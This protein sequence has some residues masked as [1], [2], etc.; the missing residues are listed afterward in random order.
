MRILLLADLHYTLPQFDWLVQAAPAF[1]VVAI[2][3][4]LLDIS[5][6]VP[7]NAQ[8]V[9]V[10]RYLRLL[11]ETTRV[12]V[13]SGNHDL[14]GPD[15]QG[16]QTALW[17]AEARAAGFVCEGASLRV[18]DALI[19]VCP[20]WDGPL[21]RAAVEAQLAADAATRP[22]HWIWV[23]HWPPF[24][25]PT[26][27]TGKRH[28]GDRDV[29]DWIARL[30]PDFVLTGHV[31]EPPFKASGH[32]AE[33]IARTWVFNAGRQIGP[34]PTHIEIDLGAGTARWR[35]L[36]GEEALSLAAAAAPDR[37]VF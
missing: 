23:Y 34:V 26:C 22:A 21:G 10:L 4:D 32:W 5:S 30:Q 13:G 17:L 25:S 3:G 11:Q 7:L 18:G 12:V 36:M 15:A 2:A 31:H 24:G 16:E 1:D 6:P 29:V 33:R 27:W 14:T 19:S 20:W 9:V 35:S 28:Y 8:A 37:S